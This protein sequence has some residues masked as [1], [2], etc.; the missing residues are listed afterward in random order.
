MMC[1]VTELVEDMDK[2][3]ES[4]NKVT[5]QGYLEIVVKCQKCQ[6]EGLGQVHRTN[7]RRCIW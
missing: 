3:R 5:F 7:T 1:D 2:L 4:G 6:K